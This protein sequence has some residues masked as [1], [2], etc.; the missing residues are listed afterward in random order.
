MA[1]CLFAI[2]FGAAGC[3]VT[4]PYA[5]PHNHR[6]GNAH[7][8]TRARAALPPRSARPLSAPASARAV[9][10]AFARAWTNWSWRTI[11]GS[12]RQRAL[13][14]TG[15]LRRQLSRDRAGAQA[16]A[17]LARDRIASRGAVL[18]IDLQ[19]RSPAYVV[20]RETQTSAGVE[21]IGDSAIR[22]Y[23]ARLARTARGWLV[24]AWAP[25]D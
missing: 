1:L 22:V 10:T 7:K 13:L 25:L 18:A 9:L 12:E 4:D 8:A 20:V 11:L 21:A 5:R 24:A 19:R 16:D 14:A 17:T 15:A 3:G 23:R 2:G 6:A